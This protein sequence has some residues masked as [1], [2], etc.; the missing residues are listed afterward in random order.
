LGT[1]DAL[2]IADAWRLT[3]ISY[4]IENLLTFVGR[5]FFDEVGAICITKGIFTYIVSYSILK[6]D[7]RFRESNT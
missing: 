3:N 5:C 4:E 2:V 7:I 6:L 1:V